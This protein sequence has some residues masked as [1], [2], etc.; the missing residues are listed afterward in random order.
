MKQKENMIVKEDG[1]KIYPL[2]YKIIIHF[3]AC[4]VTS[5][6]LSSLSAVT[7]CSTK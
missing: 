5:L 7:R 4:V 2:S 1:F 6:S 3:E